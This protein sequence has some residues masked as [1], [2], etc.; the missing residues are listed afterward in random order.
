MDMAAVYPK[1]VARKVAFVPG[2]YF[3]A[4]PGQGFETLRLNF[5]MTDERTLKRAVAVLGDV[6]RDE[7]SSLR[8]RLR[9]ACEG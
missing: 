4:Q 2:Q 5:T 6:L 9:Q 1:A 3:Y 8:D 7:S